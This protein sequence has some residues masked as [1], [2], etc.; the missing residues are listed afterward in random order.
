[1]C[2]SYLE[3]FRQVAVVDLYESL[4]SQDS[5]GCSLTAVRLLLLGAPLEGERVNT[6]RQSSQVGWKQGWGVTDYKN[7]NCNRLFYKLKYCNQIIDSFEKLD[8]YFEDYF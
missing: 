7:V 8:D 4:F 1:V 3:V 5:T 2:T 6:V